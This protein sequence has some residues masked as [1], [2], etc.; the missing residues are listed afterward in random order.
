[1]TSGFVEQLRNV[2]DGKFVGVE[3][4]VQTFFDFLPGKLKNFGVNLNA[5]HIITAR[6]EY[7]PVESFPGEFDSTNTSKWTGNATLFYDTPS[8][9]A[10]V[11]Y[12]YRSSYR[13]GIWLDREGSSR[14]SPY[15]AATDRLDAA[16]NY[17]PV[18]FMTLSLEATN[19]LGSDVKRYHGAENLL[20]L[21]VRTLARTVQGG[22][23]F[24]F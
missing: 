18:P 21:G 13:L 19:I 24:R 20:P 15:N 22:I 11:A 1:M 7:A 23:R 12:N 14:Y 9:S 17:T 6:V 3:G 5:S 8:F 16:I 4:T 10:R 2:G